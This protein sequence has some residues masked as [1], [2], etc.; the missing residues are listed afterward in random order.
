MRAGGT[1][2]ITEMGGSRTGD[3]QRGGRAS[4]RTVRPA[5]GHV[6]T[7]VSAQT[8]AQAE[9]AAQYE[10]DQ[11]C[12]ASFTC[13]NAGMIGTVVGAAA[14][15]VV[16]TLVTAVCSAASFGTLTVGC[17]VLGGFVG[18]F[19]GGAVGSLTTALLDNKKD[20]AGSLVGGAL[21]DAYIG[22]FAGAIGGAVGGKLAAGLLKPVGSAIARTALGA[23][24]GAVSAAPGGAF[25]GAAYAGLDYLN[26][27]TNCNLS[28]A[29]AAVGPGRT[30]R[31]RDRG[32][33]RRGGGGIGAAAARNSGRAAAP[34]P[35][36]NCNSFDPDT[37]V[38]MADG[39]TKPIKDV[40][41]GRSCH[42]HRPADRR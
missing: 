2:E 15:I 33:L 28:D 16:G 41:A 36:P 3:N 7:Y 18:G 24:G 1:G 19:V 42:R 22:G 9:H 39:T 5:A 21:I 40:Q 32:P 34:K 25:A 35:R 31:R 4:M 12:Q 23:V 13:R 26:T 17:V 30:P 38:A 11:A 20:T 37:P 6:D 10:K 14:S 8:E 27:C 29:A